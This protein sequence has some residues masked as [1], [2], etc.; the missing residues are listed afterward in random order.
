MAVGGQGRGRRRRHRSHA[1][2]SSSDRADHGRHRLGLHRARVSAATILSPARRVGGIELQL[3]TVAPP[4]TTLAMGRRGQPTGASPTD[5]AEARPVRDR[6]TGSVAPPTL[7]ACSA[8]RRAVPA[9]RVRPRGRAA[10]RPAAAT[11]RS[12]RSSRT[13]STIITAALTSR[14]RQRASTSTPLWTASCRSTLPGSS[15][16]TEVD[17]DRHDGER[18]RRPRGRRGPGDVLG[19]AV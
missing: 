18:R 16:S 3:D 15:A 7:S 5:L 2:P 11:L 12:A 9:R 1:E 13:R 19:A 17:A 10:P 4:T 8:A 6:L 14:R